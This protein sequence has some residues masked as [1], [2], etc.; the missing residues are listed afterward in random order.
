MAII[1]IDNGESYSDHTIYFVEI[2]DLNPQDIADLLEKVHPEFYVKAYGTLTW[3]NGETGQLHDLFH[4]HFYPTEEK[5]RPYLSATPALR[6]ALVEI[7][8]RHLE[9]RPEAPDT[10]RLREC[11]EPFK[12]FVL[13]GIPSRF[14]SL[15][16]DFE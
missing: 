16:R 13:D 11:F 2:G 3:Y 6:A 14:A 12:K 9:E 8:T 7:W 1:V 15:N 5:L 4:D 10:I